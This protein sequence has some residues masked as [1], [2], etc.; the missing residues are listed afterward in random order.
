MIAN[1]TPRTFG[2]LMSDDTDEN[3]MLLAYLRDRDVTC[4]LCKYNLRGLTTPRCP[5]CGRD[6]ELTVA[7]S[8]PYLSAWASLAILLGASGGIGLLI[9]C[10]IPSQGLPT[11]LTPGM[12]R[13][14]KIACAYHILI[15]PCAPAVVIWRR[16]L[17]RMRK[18]TQWT[19]FAVVA[20]V[21]AAM[22]FL[23]TLSD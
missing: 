15:L 2:E 22:L 9:L 23:L 11:A 21:G 4:P 10:F 3:T 1:L 16:F 13:F 20:V 6:L 7:V 8:V 18:R 17:L 12:D 5:E 19:L 14:V